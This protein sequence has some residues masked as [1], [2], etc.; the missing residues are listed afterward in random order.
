MFTYACVIGVDSITAVIE[1][2]PITQAYVNNAYFYI[3][4]A[5]DAD[6]D[7]LT[8]Q[9]ELTNRDTGAEADFLR[10]TNNFVQG[11]PRDDD[12]GEYDV[13]IIVSDGTDAAVQA[14]ILSVE[15]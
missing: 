1:S 2:T 5:S 15:E 8:Y 6:G 11:T 3:V 14:F 4:S 7:S 10:F 13:R 12:V 9:I